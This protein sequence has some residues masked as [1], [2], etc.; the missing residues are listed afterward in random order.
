MVSDNGGVNVLH[1]R[2][3]SYSTCKFQAIL[4]YFDTLKPQDLTVGK[5]RKIGLMR[6][7]KVKSFLKSFFKMA[8]ELLH[9]FF[10]V[11]NPK[12]FHLEPL[13]RQELETALTAANRKGDL[14][15]VKEIA[16][17]LT[18]HCLG[19]L[20]N[21]AASFPGLKDD[22]A[23]EG[24]DALQELVEQV[25]KRVGL[26]DSQRGS[27]PTF[28]NQVAMSS[29][30]KILSELSFGP[31]LRANYPPHL[32]SIAAFPTSGEEA[33]D[34]FLS[35]R[36]VEGVVIR[37]ESLEEID[38]AIKE[39]RKKKNRIS[40]PMRVLEMSAAGMTHKEIG[41]VLDITHQAVSQLY[42]R[43]L[44]IVRRYLGLPKSKDS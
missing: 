23:L 36:P 7:N 22:P 24:D 37:K 29:G 28:A 6:I 34:S 40:K 5:F 10:P 33:Q 13:K 19:L 2:V 12:E 11:A 14:E 1:L 3:L 27:F 18:L 16:G 41:I 42:A 26:F 4:L 44:N 32:E 15:T 35:P 17:K 8:K 21:A 20:S 43:G 25:L 9:Q 31:F 39:L 38:T 30:G